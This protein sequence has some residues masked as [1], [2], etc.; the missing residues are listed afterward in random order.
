MTVQ[1]GENVISGKLA[2]IVLMAGWASSATRVRL[3]HA[4]TL[5]GIPVSFISD[6]ILYFF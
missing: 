6:G 5:T 1:T 3:T 4:H 2:A